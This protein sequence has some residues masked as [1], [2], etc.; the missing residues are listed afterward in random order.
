MT[1]LPSSIFLNMRLLSSLTEK[2]RFQL[3]PKT[4]HLMHKTMVQYMY[5]SLL[6]KNFSLIDVLGALSTKG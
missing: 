2:L 4:Q 3:L 6:S 1:V 5:K